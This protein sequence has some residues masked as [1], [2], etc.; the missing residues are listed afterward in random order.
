ME[1]RNN[2]FKFVF[3][4][5]E[6]DI[7]GETKDIVIFDVWRNGEWIAHH[8]IESHEAWAF[9]DWLVSGQLTHLVEREQRD[10]STCHRD[11]WF[12]G[13]WTPCGQAILCPACEY[14]Q[15]ADRPRYY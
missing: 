9:A 10:H 1:F 13:E 3:E 12:E 7:L 14:A 5:E 11:V 8:H 2:T 15:E 6:A 4:H